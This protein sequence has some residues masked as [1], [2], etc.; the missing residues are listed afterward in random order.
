MLVSMV[1][2][3][4]EHADKKVT[5][6]VKIL[7][8]SNNGVEVETVLEPGSME[9]RTRIMIPI[10]HIT[11]PVALNDYLS[12]T[13]NGVMLETCPVQLEKIYSVKKTEYT[14]STN[15]NTSE[16]TT[17]NTESGEP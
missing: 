13:Y 3:S 17:G 6:T 10:E 2:C 1:G 16:E 12:I 9:T 4:K 11:E 14:P 5:A 15:T 8:L 7:G